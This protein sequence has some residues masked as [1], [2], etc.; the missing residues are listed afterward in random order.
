MKPNSNILEIGAGTGQATAHFISGEYNL[1]ALELGKEQVGFLKQK[2]PEINVQCVP[3]ENYVSEPNRFDLIFSA[4]A[5]HWINAQIGYPKAYELLKYN[6]TMVVF[7]HTSSITRF[8]DKIHTGIRNICEKYDPNLYQGKT[9]QELEDI[10]KV[11][12][13]EITTNGLFKN[14]YYKE[15]VWID[16]YDAEKYIALLNTYSDFQV[17]DSVKR[18]MLLEEIKSFIVSNGGIVEMPQKVNLYMAKKV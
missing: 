6:G 9:V 17:F 13:N 5:F 14:P 18:K 8:E 15:Y 4:T 2:Y 10:H 16:Y 7:W 11:R 1:T 12:I 3:F